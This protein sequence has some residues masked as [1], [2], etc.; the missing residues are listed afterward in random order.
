V[1]A[2]VAFGVG[3]SLRATPSPAPVRFHVAAPESLT[4]MGSPRLSPDGRLLAFNATDSNGATQVWVRPLDA[5]EA[6][7]V[8]GTEGAGRP[9]WSPDSRFIGFFANGKL[10]KVAASGG[11]SQSLCDVTFGADASWGTRGVILFDGR[12][13]DPLRRCPAAGGVVTHE[14]D[15]NPEGGLNGAAWPEFLP[16]GRHYLYSAIRAGEEPM[17]MVRTL[18]SDEE[19]PLLETSSRVQYAPPGYLL[20]VR[21]DT[22]V[23]QPFD[24]GSRKLTGEAVPVAEGLGMDA[25]GLAHFS[26]SLDG[27]LAFRAGET[28]TRQLLW[29]DR[30]GEELGAVGDAGEYGDIWPS[31]DGQRLVFDMPEQGTGS[32]DL[33]IRDLGRGVTSRF[34]FD[35]GNDSTPVWSPDG[36]TIVFTSDRGGVSGDLYRKLASGTGEE[37]VLLANEEEKYACDWSRDGRFI[38]YMS[39]GR[40]TRWDVWALPLEGEAEPFPIVKTRFRE[41]TPSLSPDG[42]FVAYVSNESGQNEVYV[43]EFPEPRSKWQVST[44]GGND[45]SW[46]ADGK[47][48]YY[49]SPDAKIMS[50]SVET[51]RAFTAG[52][53]TALFQARLQ[54][55]VVRSRFRPSPDGQRFLTLAP[56][57]RD[58][59]LPTTVVLN[60]PA[61]LND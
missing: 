43:Q 2:A 38:V 15:T 12:P 35:A 9:F 8:A 20:Y 48:I 27:S 16:D 14:I 7:P 21:E 13:S 45:P 18:D 47:E 23:A 57:G 44:G 54:P 29:V 34:T 58:N 61:T 37:E 28:R 56:L 46:R 59:I 55:A 51:S 53:P 19:A 22:L 17:L 41:M 49:R 60:W 39:R 40:E 25:V 24:A 6:R 1:A 26:A 50:V 10:K 3:L 5:I 33:W 30:Q 11:P 36:R 52:A 4:V 32:L 31:P 42:R